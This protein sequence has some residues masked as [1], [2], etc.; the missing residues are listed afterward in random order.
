M[1]HWQIRKSFRSWMINTREDN[2]VLKSIYPST[3]SSFVASCCTIKCVQN[4]FSPTMLTKSNGGNSLHCLHVVASLVRLPETM[5]AGKPV[6][7]LLKLHRKIPP[8]HCNKLYI[9][10]LHCTALHCTVLLCT[11][12]YCQRCS[13]QPLPRLY[14]GS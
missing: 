11:A 6:I 10:A 13:Q 9:T 2:L 12:L 5:E 14:T 4:M 7:H 1:E 8:L 3:I